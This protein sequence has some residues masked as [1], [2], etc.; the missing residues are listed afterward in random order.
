MGR[1]G[2]RNH[3]CL[4]LEFMEERGG[5][6][7]TLPAQSLAGV[8]IKGKHHRLPSLVRH[9]VAARICTAVS[10]CAVLRAKMACGACAWLNV[11]RWSEASPFFF[12]LMWWLREGGLGGGR[13]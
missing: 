7:F 9:V 12:I 11:R 3:N 2:M 5:R 10:T 8:L 6:D 13:E 1:R 4:D